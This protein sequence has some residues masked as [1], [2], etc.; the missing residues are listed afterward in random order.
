M[1]PTDEQTVASEGG[2]CPQCGRYNKSGI[3]YCFNCRYPLHTLPK[4]A[5]GIN[6][7]G[8]IHAEGSSEKISASADVKTAP[9]PVIERPRTAPPL[10]MRSS[11]EPMPTAS[12]ATKKAITE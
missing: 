11:I 4:Q 2:L 10:Q 1:I 3:H 7:N 6:G 5:Q 12:I 9:P 8:A